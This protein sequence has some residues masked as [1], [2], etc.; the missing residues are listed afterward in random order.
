MKYLQCGLR[1][2]VSAARQ[3]ESLRPGGAAAATGTDG[4]LKM[5]CTCGVPMDGGGRP[6]RQD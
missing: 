2:P 5:V 4:H 6:A 3:I 1:R